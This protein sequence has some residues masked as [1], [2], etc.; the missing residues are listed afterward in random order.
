MAQ[1]SNASAATQTAEISQGSAQNV[2]VVAAY[3]AESMVQGVV[4]A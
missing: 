3:Q 4:N 1:K 2:N